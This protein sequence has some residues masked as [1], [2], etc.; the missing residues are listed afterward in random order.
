MHTSRPLSQSWQIN[1]QMPMFLTFPSRGPRRYPEVSVG[2]SRASRAAGVASVVSVEHYQ[3]Q[4][5]SQR[6]QAIGLDLFLH[7]CVNLGKY[8]ISLNLRFLLNFRTGLRIQINLIWGF[9]GGSVV[10]NLPAHAG[11]VDEIPGSG[12]SPGEGNGNPLQ[13]Y[14]L[15]NPMDRGAW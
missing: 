15:E 3:L 7:N 12:R 4:I 8:L 2:L 11:D 10:K 9:L 5:H 13:N 1:K 14:C 6:T